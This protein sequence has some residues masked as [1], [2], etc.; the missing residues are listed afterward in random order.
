V[1]LAVIATF[2]TLGAAY[3]GNKGSLT[4][5]L[6]GSPT[7][8]I[9]EPAPT[10]TI[11][12][13]VSPGQTVSSQELGGQAWHL[14]KMHFPLYTGIDIDADSPAVVT[15]YGGCLYRSGVG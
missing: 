15:K 10:V 4:G 7:Q 9:T 3:L 11:T 13:T 8:T 2:G 12:R 5:V 14:D 1:I 6:P